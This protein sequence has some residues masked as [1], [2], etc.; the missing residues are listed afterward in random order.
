[1]N[2]NILEGHIFIFYFLKESY[3]LQE[4]YYYSRIYVIKY[5]NVAYFPI[6]QE[7]GECRE[8]WEYIILQYLEKY[9]YLTNLQALKKT[10]I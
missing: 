9:R 5:S 1:M 7:K 10:C 8:N 4:S 2:F 6:I 3:Y